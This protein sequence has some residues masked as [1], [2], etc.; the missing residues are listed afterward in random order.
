[1][2]VDHP[3][4]AP[5]PYEDEMS[6]IGPVRLAFDSPQVSHGSRFSPRE[7]Y[8]QSWGMYQAAY[9]VGLARA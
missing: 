2:T 9:E 1:M 3:I 6:N 4:L 8:E 7:Q 5:E